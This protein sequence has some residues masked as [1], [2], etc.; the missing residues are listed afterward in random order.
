MIAGVNAST[1]VGL[2]AEHTVQAISASFETVNFKVI[3]SALTAKYGSPIRVDYSMIITADG[4]QFDQTVNIWQNEAGDEIN[5]SR[6]L[7]DDVR[8]GSIVLRTRAQIYRPTA[9]GVGQ[10]KEN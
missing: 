10:R 7:R 6:Y 5:L 1:L 2:D 3:S 4:K 8:F 9:M